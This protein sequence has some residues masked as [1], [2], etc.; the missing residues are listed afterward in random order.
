MT[1]EVRFEGRF[2]SFV[3]EYG[4]EFVE[5]RRTSGVVAII[6]VTPTGSMLLVEQHRPPV[7]CPVIEIPA[8]L[9]GD[10]SGA[11]DEAFATAAAREL[12]EETGYLPRLLR[13][14]GTGPSSS[15][16][17]SE[18]ITFFEASDLQKT[19][20]GGGDESESITVH[21]V[22][23]N[24]LRGWLQQQSDRGALIDPKIFAGLCMAGIPLP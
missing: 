17:T 9:A 14:L 20:D 7:G 22:P 15:G 1:R 18:L 3:A 4:W 2:L 19:G 10:I 5:R 13:E 11:E 6:A 24:E 23:L 12:E 8:G 21:E 16:L